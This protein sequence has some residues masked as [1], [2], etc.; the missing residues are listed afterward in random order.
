MLMRG[1]LKWPPNHSYPAKPRLPGRG[2]PTVQEILASGNTSEPP[3][4]TRRSTKAR[5]PPYPIGE[6][7][8][9]Y[10]GTRAKFPRSPSMHSEPSS[11]ATELLRPET[12]CRTPPEALSQREV[13]SVTIEIDLKA[14][15]EYWVEEASSEFPGETPSRRRGSSV[16]AY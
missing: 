11:G 13:A 16:V 1:T 12:P 15:D 10:P 5:G 7:K 4:K 8:P 3:G 9:E 6:I 2:F 14:V